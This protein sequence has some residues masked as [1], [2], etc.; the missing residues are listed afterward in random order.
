VGNYDNSTSRVVMLIAMT[1]A[2]DALSEVLHGYFHKH[3]FM[4]II[5]ISRLAKGGLSLILFVTLMFHTGSLTLGLVGMLLASFCTL[6]LFD[7]PSVLCI[8]PDSMFMSIMPRLNVRCI[9]SLIWVSIPAGLSTG[10]MSLSTNIPRYFIEYKMD[11][12]SLGIF[13]AL[14]YT[15]VAGEMIMRSVRQA[16]LPRLVHHHKNYNTRAFS[17]ILI[18]LLCFGFA[19]GVTGVLIASSLGPMI[20]GWLYGKEYSDQSHVFLWLVIAN[21]IRMSAV[22]PGA[23]RA[24]NLYW[25]DLSIR[26]CGIITLTF[27]L[28]LLLPTYGLVGAA[29]AIVISSSTSSILCI[30]AVIIKLNEINKLKSLGHRNMSLLSKGA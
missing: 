11:A 5:A 6:A 13:A 19:L 26:I 15:L 29:Y 14:A 18:K 24:M 10:L 1:K 7:I 2:V 8:I 27:S 20:V 16:I 3:E 22:P 12:N 17:K 28:T 4:R 21:A 23:L 9:F 25:L 30:V